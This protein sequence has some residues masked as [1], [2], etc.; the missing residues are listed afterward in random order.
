MNILLEEEVEINTK[1]NN[2]RYTEAIYSENGAIVFKSTND[3]SKNISKEDIKVL[4]GE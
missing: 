4:L 2:A 1:P 3:K